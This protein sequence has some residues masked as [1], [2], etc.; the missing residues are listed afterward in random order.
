MFETIIEK[1]DIS[2]SVNT[3]ENVS[4]LISSI[5]TFSQQV[6]YSPLLNYLKEDVRFYFSFIN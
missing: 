6:S 1:F 3:H 2:N 4:Q 5:V